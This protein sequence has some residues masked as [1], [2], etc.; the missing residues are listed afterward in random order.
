[1]LR[2]R[3]LRQGCRLSRSSA[4]A[5]C[6]ALPV[7]LAACVTETGLSGKEETTMKADRGRRKPLWETKNLVEGPK[8]LQAVLPHL[9]L[10]VLCPYALC[11]NDGLACKNSWGE[12]PEL[13]VVDEQYQYIGL[14][15]GEAVIDELHIVESY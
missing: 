11:V 12:L 15:D 6:C 4:W 9:V 5:Q 13:F 10:S 7:L 2:N 8:P 14:L 1:M 3:G